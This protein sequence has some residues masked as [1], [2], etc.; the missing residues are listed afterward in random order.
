M[1]ALAFAAAFTSCTKENAPAEAPAMREVTLSVE[2]AEPAGTRVGYTANEDTYKFAWTSTDKLLVFYYDESADGLTGQAVFT[3]DQL[4]GKQATFSGSL[5][6]TV[7]DVLIVYSSKDID[8]PGFGLGYFD[9]SFYGTTVTD[10]DSVTNALTENTFL[11]AFAAIENGG[12][13]P[14][15]KLQH[16]LAYLLLEKGL[17]MLNNETDYSI[18]ALNLTTYNS[19]IFFDSNTIWS[20]SLEDGGFAMKFNDNGCL[21]SDYLIP[22]HP[23]STA[24]RLCFSFEED[25]VYGVVFQQSYTY[26]PGVIYKVAADNEKWVPI[27]VEEWGEEEW[28]DDDD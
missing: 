28:D 18:S 20:D 25:D 6:A 24:F 1:L 13:L 11:Y 12:A 14:N 21:T 15:V 17:K 27:E 7:E 2:V 23:E 4:N 8:D 16:G 19:C 26:K 10:D 9:V 22:F 3:I 5:P